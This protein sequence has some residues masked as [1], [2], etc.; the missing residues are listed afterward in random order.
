MSPLMYY[1]DNEFVSCYETIAIRSMFSVV[2]VITPL[3]PEIRLDKSLPLK[4][5][6]EN[7]ADFG[8][9]P[10]TVTIIVID[11]FF[12]RPRPVVQSLS[13]PTVID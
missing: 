10:I 1:H 8:I 7:S 12:H 13:S 11:F 5:T 6:L 9:F 3:P 4:T 2:S